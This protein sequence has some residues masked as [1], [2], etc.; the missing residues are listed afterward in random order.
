MQKIPLGNT[1]EKISCMA[2]GTMYFG[3]KIDEQTA[4]LLLDYYHNQGGDFLDS[5][6]KYASWVPGF[7]GGESELLIGK[8]LKQKANRNEIFLATKVG[9]PYC[10]VPHSLKKDII[11]SECEKSLKR[12]GVETIDLY[13]AHV[14]DATTP[15]VEVMETFSKLKKQGKIRFAGASNYFGWQLSQANNATIGFD[16][17]GFVCLQQ[18]H[19]FLEPGL[20]ANFG[21][22]QVLSPEIEEYS[23]TQNLTLM[24]YSP[25]LGGAYV[26]PDR[27][28]PIQYQNAA[29]DLKINN[30]K[31]VA[32]DLQVSPNAV[33]LRWMIQASPA[34][35]PIMTGSSEDQLKENMETFSFI[36]NDE[37]L[38]I[39]NQDIVQANKYS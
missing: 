8:W 39:L 16:F 18:R 28:I 14:Y 34:V 12:L 36:L 11:I 38:G 5:A 37:Q 29:N 13:F 6:N 27:P 32:K 2:L 20:R 24:A 31:Q 4:F 22:Q 7:K 33:V 30:L 19:T 21:T 26:N 35:I 17:D 10:S 15:A 23:Q 25:L 3:T 1:N 9:F